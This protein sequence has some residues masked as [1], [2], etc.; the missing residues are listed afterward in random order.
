MPEPDLLTVPQVAAT[1]GVSRGTVARWI[2]DGVLGSVKLGRH[3]RVT[4]GQLD[5]FFNKL[6]REGQVPPAWPYERPTTSPISTP[7]RKGDGR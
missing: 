3:R 2:A 5:A 1:L 7:V 6:E 4:R